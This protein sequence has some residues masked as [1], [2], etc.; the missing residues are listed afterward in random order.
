[1]DTR[2]NES[3]QLKKIVGEVVSIIASDS[4]IVAVVPEGQDGV[5]AKTREAYMIAATPQ[6]FEVC[7]QLN[8][9]LEN[10]LVV[11]PKGTH[12]DCTDVK[13]SLHAAIMRAKGCRKSPDEP[14]SNCLLQ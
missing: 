7:S 12:I 5:G 13:K 9:I 10:N 6:L 11:T 4:T 14:P 1:M 3:W 2:N 8:A